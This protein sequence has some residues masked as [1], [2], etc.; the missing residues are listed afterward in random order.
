M[1]DRALPLMLALLC[2]ALGA[3]LLQERR[4]ILVGGRSAPPIPAP[5]REGLE[6]A[7][8]AQLTPD[9]VARGARALA[10]GEGPGLTP[11]QRAVLLPAAAAG[12]DARRAVDRLREERR[13]QEQGYRAALAQIAA[14]TGRRGTPQPPSGQLSYPPSGQLPYPPSGQLPYPPSG[15]L[16]YPPS[17]QPPYP[18]GQ[19]PYPPGA[20]GPR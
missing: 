5:A 12:H 15:Q 6:P 14:A 20:P 19:P 18:P 2:V 9:D 17:G 1:N 11:D 8:A 16:P 13:R 7:F 10:L 3:A 4:P